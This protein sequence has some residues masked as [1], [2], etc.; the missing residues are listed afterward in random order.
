MRFV[1]RLGKTVKSALLLIVLVNIT[2]KA[3]EIGLQ[4]H[5]F[6]DLF[7]KDVP[8]TMAKVRKMGVK[9][10]E[11][12]GT[13]GL[14]FPEFIKILAQNEISVVSY[15][16]EYEKLKNFPQT[17]ADEA[18]SYGAKYVVIFS[19]PFEGDSFTAE[20]VDKAAAVF[21][22]AGK[23]IA[24]NGLMLCYHP[25]GYEFKPYKDGTLFDYMVQKFDSRFVQFEL[26][27]FWVKQAGQ[28]PLELLKKYPNR[29]VL[30]HVKD[31]KKGTKNTDNGKA[32]EESNVV[33]GTGD[34]GIVEV[35]REARKLGIQ[36]LFVEDESS[37]AEEQVLKSIRFLR[38]VR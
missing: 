8:G 1:H 31:R 14:E 7:A 2:S 34:V 19:I 21:N 15:G 22:A 10:V 24:R 30:M 4:L 6:R 38:T 26:D 17:L 28:D 32:D 13:Y 12:N 27:V 11:L 20:D 3:Q 18:R 9:E 25:H 35:V 23:L 29:F 5:S 36:H 33:L 37:K 16:A